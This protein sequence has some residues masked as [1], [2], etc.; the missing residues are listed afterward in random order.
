MNVLRSCE[1]YPRYNN[2]EY[3]TLHLHLDLK[4]DRAVNTSIL[5]TVSVET[6]SASFTSRFKYHTKNPSFQWQHVI[7][8]V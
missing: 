1:M 3:G 2:Q 5:Q 7:R 6:Y 8:T 4:N